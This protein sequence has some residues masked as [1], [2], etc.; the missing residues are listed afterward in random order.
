MKKLVYGATLAVLSIG[1]VACGTSVND[2]GSIKI[3]INTTATGFDLYNSYTMAGGAYLP[4]NVKGD[5]GRSQRELPY[6]L[7]PTL[8]SGVPQATVTV[9]N[10]DT[11]STVLKA[12][13]KPNAFDN[14]RIEFVFLNGNTPEDNLMLNLKIGTFEKHIPLNIIPDDN[15]VPVKTLVV[16]DAAGTPVSSVDGS[17]DAVQVVVAGGDNHDAVDNSGKFEFDFGNGGTISNPDVSVV[18]DNPDAFKVKLFYKVEGESGGYYLLVLPNA[19]GESATLKIES[20][21]KTADG[22]R[23]RTTLKL[24]SI[25]AT[26]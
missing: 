15:W 20:V 12:E 8:S 14:G 17:A 16:N 13:A 1:V 10:T 25:A 2:D 5:S 6:T 7:L 3:N 24:E 4:I 23:K 18:N 21:G 26:P 22:A 9:G 11:E 19:P